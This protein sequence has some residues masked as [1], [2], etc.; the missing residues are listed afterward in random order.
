MSSLTRQCPFDGCGV[1]ISPQLFACS[2][3][4]RSLSPARKRR[5]WDE[6]Q[7]KAR[8]RQEAD[9]AIHRSPGGTPHDLP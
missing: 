6:A 1:P 7:G 4:W 3:H 8:A 5:V 2:R 9:R